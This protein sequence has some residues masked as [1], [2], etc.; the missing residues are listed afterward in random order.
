[1]N[2]RKLRLAGYVCLIALSIL[3]GFAMQSM[4]QQELNDGSLGVAV[5]DLTGIKT[6]ESDIPKLPPK[7]YIPSVD[8]ETGRTAWI[9]YVGEGMLGAE[10]EMGGDTPIEDRTLKR[11]CFCACKD[12]LQPTGET[13]G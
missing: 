7:L 5:I 9:E 12:E 2:I 3:M 13:D 8:P 1:M 4:A 10:Y 6:I 11:P